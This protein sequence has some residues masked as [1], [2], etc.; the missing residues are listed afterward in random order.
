MEV[1]ICNWGGRKTAKFCLIR[2]FS[3]KPLVQWYSAFLFYFQHESWCVQV[4][5]IIFVVASA[6]PEWRKPVITGRNFCRLIVTLDA[7]VKML[8]LTL[9]IITIINFEYLLMDFLY[10]VLKSTC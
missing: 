6:V 9:I 5:C 3:R 1:A 7:T 10:M 2:V 8:E 4:F